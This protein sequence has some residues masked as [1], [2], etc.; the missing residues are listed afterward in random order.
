M[1]LGSED[2]SEP[3]WFVSIAGTFATPSSARLGEES[4]GLSPFIGIQGP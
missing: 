4:S 1:Q 2:G 3:V